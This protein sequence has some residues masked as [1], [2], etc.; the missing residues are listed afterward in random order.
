MKLLFKSPKKTKFVLVEVPAASA[1]FFEGRKNAGVP[2]SVLPENLRRQL[3]SGVELNASDVESIELASSF[4]G[5]DS[6]P[7]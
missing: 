1:K 2:V 3:A 6:K 4:G 5:D 7:A